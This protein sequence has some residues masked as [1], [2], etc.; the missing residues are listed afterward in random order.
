MQIGTNIALYYTGIGERELYTA[1]LERNRVVNGQFIF[2]IC[3]VLIFTI[4]IL[5][6]SDQFVYTRFSAETGTAVS[7]VSFRRGKTIKILRKITL[8]F[9]KI[10][11]FRYTC[12]LRRESKMNKKYL[13]V[14]FA[15]VVSLSVSVGAFAQDPFAVTRD[16]ETVLTFFNDV[17]L[18]FPDMF[19]LEDSDY[20]WTENDTEIIPNFETY[21]KDV[22]AEEVEMEAKAPI[23]KILKV[24]AT[25]DPCGDGLIKVDLELTRSTT[26]SGT[27]G[28][29]PKNKTYIRDII[30]TRNGKNL[31]IAKCESTGS[32]NCRS[33]KFSSKGVAKMTLYVYSDEVIT[34][35]S[36]DLGYV[37]VTLF[38][39]NYMTALFDMPVNSPVTGSGKLTRDMKKNYC[40]GQL[41]EYDPRTAK[42]HTMSSV[43]AK[44]DQNTY[45]RIF[46]Q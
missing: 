36:S 23:D 42:S 14:L 15:L 6:L 7:F 39:S 2:V 8:K 31:A 16:E 37:D 35:G 13:A 25:A 22:S 9:L 38:D 20:L 10:L 45:S 46:Q 40:Q 30:V 26:G 18:V 4:G 32:D 28:Y 43:R 27:P 24:T 33:V 11:F 44:Y 12:I 19:A 5:S 3:P 17:N 1:H 29:G 21:A 41:T 34:D